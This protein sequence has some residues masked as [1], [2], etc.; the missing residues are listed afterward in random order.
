MIKNCVLT[1]KATGVEAGPNRSW[2]VCL[3][4]FDSLIT[5]ESKNASKDPMGILKLSR[6]LTIK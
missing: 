3:F 1:P 4:D 2:A 5:V 6:Q